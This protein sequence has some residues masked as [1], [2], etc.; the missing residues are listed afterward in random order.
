M[1]L[2]WFWFDEDGDEKARASIEVGADISTNAIDEHE[3]AAAAAAARDLMGDENAATE[4]KEK[5]RRRSRL[6]RK[7][8]A[9]GWLPCPWGLPT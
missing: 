3:T 8:T 5:G 6:R 7:M 4:K 9:R 2:A 1:I